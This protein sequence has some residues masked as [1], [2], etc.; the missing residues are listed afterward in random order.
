MIGNLLGYFERRKKTKLYQQWAKRD[1]LPPEDIPPDLL[2]DEKG[3]LHGQSVEE[4]D[5]PYEDVPRAEVPKTTRLQDV[6]S[7]HILVPI[8]YI[9]LGVSLITVLLIILFVVLTI[10]LMQSC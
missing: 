10:L 5:L 9:L 6:D 4:T 3:R 2:R 8:R 1:G 7:G